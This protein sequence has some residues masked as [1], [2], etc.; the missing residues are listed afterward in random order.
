MSSFEPRII[1]F[2]CNWCPSVFFFVAPALRARPRKEKNW[3]KRNSGSPAAPG[4]PS[5]C[6]DLGGLVP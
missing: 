4:A 6:S 3:E 1:A 2:C 5:L